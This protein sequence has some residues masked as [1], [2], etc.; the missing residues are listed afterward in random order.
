M[1][2]GNRKRKRTDRAA[3]EEA[4]QAI[5]RDKEVARRIER[6]QDDALE[7]V[8]LRNETLAVYEEVRRRAAARE[9]EG[10]KIAGKEFDH[11]VE[12]DMERLR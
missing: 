10:A 9:S 2:R 11:N 12:D 4:A 1:R 8:K 6:E 3:A 5:W 7:R